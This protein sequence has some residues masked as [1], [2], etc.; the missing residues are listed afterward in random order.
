MGDYKIQYLTS[1]CLL[2]TFAIIVAMFVQRQFSLPSSGFL[3]MVLVL[4]EPKAVEQHNN[5]WIKCAYQ[6]WHN[7]HHASMF[8]QQATTVNKEIVSPDRTIL[9]TVNADT[10]KLKKPR[11]AR[12]HVSVKC[13]NYSWMLWRGV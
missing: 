9:T 3:T 6:L 5:E 12:S 13:G 11:L 2:L 8:C 7:L 10:V 1:D 4:P